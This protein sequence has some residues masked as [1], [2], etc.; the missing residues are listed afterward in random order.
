MANMTPR[1]LYH[2]CSLET[3]QNIVEN[4]SIWLSDVQKSND[5][6]ELEWIKG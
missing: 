1:I 5:S 3:F 4:K 2:Y 6:K